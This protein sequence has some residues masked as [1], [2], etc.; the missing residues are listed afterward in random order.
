MRTSIARLVA[1]FGLLLGALAFGTAVAADGATVTETNFCHMNGST[2]YCVDVHQE[3]NKTVTPSGNIS[4]EDNAHGTFS[5][6]T[7]GHTTYAAQFNNHVHVLDKG[8][9][10][11]E[12]SINNRQTVTFPNGDTF[13]FTFHYHY[14]NGQVQFYDSDATPGAC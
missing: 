1:V 14:A 12:Q 2:L 6:T 8:G 4:V 7:S 9:S 13:C 11:Q 10:L 3:V 5:F